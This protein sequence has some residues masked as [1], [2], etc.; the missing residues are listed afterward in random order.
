MLVGGLRGGGRGLFALDI[1]D[2]TAY[3]ET[4]T[5]A[6][7]TVMWEFSSADDAD[8]GHTFS[9]PS[10]VLMPNGK[11]AVIFGNGYN[12]T[13]SGEAQLFILYLEE[14]LDRPLVVY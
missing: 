5:A 10:I 2:P 13:G 11:W 9:A 6:A 1:T 4:S 14:G 3:A 7:N 8:L 12:D